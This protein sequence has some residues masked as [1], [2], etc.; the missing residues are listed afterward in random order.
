MKSNTSFRPSDTS[1]RP[2]QLQYAL[3]LLFLLL[4]SVARAVDVAGGPANNPTD[5]T[6][7]LL[8]NQNVKFTGGFFIV[9]IPQTGT[10]IVPVNTIDAR[11]SDY[12]STGYSAPTNP[13]INYQGIIS[14]DG[15]LIV[16]SAFNTARP[17]Y[18][19]PFTG[20]ALVFDSLDPQTWGVQ[21]VTSGARSASALI[22]ETNTTVAFWFPG[23]NDQP[24]GGAP[25]GDVFPASD[26]VSRNIT[27]DG[28][29]YSGTTNHWANI[30]GTGVNSFAYWGGD[31]G[32][33]GEFP[34]T[35]YSGQSFHTA[36]GAKWSSQGIIENQPNGQATNLVTRRITVF[37]PY[38]TQSLLDQSYNPAARVKRISQNMFCSTGDL[39]FSSGGTAFTSLRGCSCQR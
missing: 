10:G 18:G 8:T 21:G 12:G 37:E 27:N 17:A 1:F 22:I 5:I 34:D 33:L 9:K 6:T 26:T 7:Y 35:H 32:V 39:I 23:E 29:M 4:A 13:A 15:T 19:Q 25:R 36:N 31:R 24:Q 28:F 30:M 20:G 3:L 2:F 11:I 38:N 16:R 14:G